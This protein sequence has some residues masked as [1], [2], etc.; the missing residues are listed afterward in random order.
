VHSAFVEE[1]GEWVINA[2]VRA[3]AVLRVSILS[4]TLFGWAWVHYKHGG[5]ADD[6]RALS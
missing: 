6:R 2:V 1:A 3:V 5:V 4:S